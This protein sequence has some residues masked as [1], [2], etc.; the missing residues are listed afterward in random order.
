MALLPES[1]RD[2][3]MLVLCLVAAALVYVYYA[4]MWSGTN[5]DLNALSAHLDTL[6]TQNEAARRDIASGETAR[7]QA[8]AQSYGTMLTSMRRLV[9]TANEVPQLLDEISTAARGAG[10]EI[11]EVTPDSVIPGPVFDTYKYHMTVQGS[12]H[13]VGELLSNVGSLT[14]IIEPMNLNLI[15]ATT[16]AANAQT[17]KGEAA[18]SASFDIQTYVAKTAPAAAPT[19]STSTKTQ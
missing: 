18:L 16:A 8:E 9:P 1:K 12:Y 5:A 2:Q 7:L 3:L 15:K 4:Y 6:T 11:G 10:L 19:P 13:R 14:R 17:R